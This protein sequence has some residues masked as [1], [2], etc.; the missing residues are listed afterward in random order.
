[1]TKRNSTKKEVKP[2]S[3]PFTENFI[4]HWERWKA[5]KKEQFYFTYKPIG[6]QGAIDELFNDLSGGDEQVA[7]QIINQ[8]INKGWRGLFQLKNLPNGTI[9]QRNTQKP[10]PTG[11]VA[12]GGFGE[13]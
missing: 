8:S 1:M 6:E 11:N 2:F 5:F 10:R 3:N 13:L 9:N 4:P 12:T 7:I